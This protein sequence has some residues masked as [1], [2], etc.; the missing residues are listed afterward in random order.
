MQI[1]FYIPLLGLV[2]IAA[3]VVL[4]AVRPFRSPTVMG[5][6][7]F[8]GGMVTLMIAVIDLIN[9]VGIIELER[10]LLF[11]SG[12]V[13]CFIGYYMVLLESRRA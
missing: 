10:V 3:N 13:N 9:P 11:V 8:F 2:L 1:S 6:Q 12:C 4:A 5:I 7:L